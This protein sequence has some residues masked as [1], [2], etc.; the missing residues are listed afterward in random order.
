MADISMT[1]LEDVSVHAW[2]IR[3][4]LIKQEIRTSKYLVH[5]I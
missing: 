2:N 3:R 5:P 4:I 1:K